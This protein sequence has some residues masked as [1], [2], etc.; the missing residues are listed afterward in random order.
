MKCQPQ[1]SKL[2]VSFT[3]AHT[4][5]EGSWKKGYKSIVNTDQLPPCPILC[6]KTVKICSATKKRYEGRKRRHLGQTELTWFSTNRWPEGWR[7]VDTHAGRERNKTGLLYLAC[8][9]IILL[10]P[11]TPKKEEAGEAEA[12]N[13]CKLLVYTLFDVFLSPLIFVYI[14][15]LSWHSPKIQ[16]HCSVDEIFLK[17]FLRLTMSALGI[18]NYVLVQF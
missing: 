9:T 18:F 2:Y 8:S 15:I 14:P 1:S 10:P 12:K 3:H 4:H 6:L 17:N 7:Q 13:P 5:G 11:S 16:R